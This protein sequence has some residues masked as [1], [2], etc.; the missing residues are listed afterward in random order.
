MINTPQ[1]AHVINLLWAVGVRIS[2]IFNVD[3]DDFIC[4]CCLLV[5]VG[6]GDDDD[7]DEDEDCQVSMLV[8]QRSVLLRLNCKIN[9]REREMLNWF[10]LL[11]VSHRFRF[12]KVCKCVCHLGF[13]LMLIWPHVSL[14]V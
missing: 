11:L 9:K 5:E 1:S 3:A 14:C 12:R 4:W 10:Q 13:G 7:E 2:F 6:G 8:G